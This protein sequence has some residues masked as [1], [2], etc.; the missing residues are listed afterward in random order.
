MIQQVLG[1]L[2]SRRRAFSAI[3]S[4]ML[5]AAC[6]SSHTEWKEEVKL[7]SGEL[8]VLKRTARLKANYIAGGGGGSI[9]QGMTVEIMTPA[10]SD[11][12]AVWSD[13]FVPVLFDRDPSTKEWFMVATFFHCDSWEQLGRPKLPYTEYRFKG[14][15]WV[16]QAL[17]PQWIGRPA[18]MYTGMGPKGVED[19]TAEQNTSRLNDPMV[20]PKY[21]AITDKWEHGC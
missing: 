13:R 9:N 12:P 11:N 7:Q 3:A 21:K 17:S 18:N 15:R 4:A 8:I 6:G 1:S 5:V 10:R 20:L 19:R 2:R 14:G 16:Q